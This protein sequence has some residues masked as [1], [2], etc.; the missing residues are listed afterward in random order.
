M[1]RRGLERCLL[2][3]FE[4]AGLDKMSFRS[5][6]E[7]VTTLNDQNEVAARLIEA[8]RGATTSTLSGC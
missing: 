7:C 1:E 5:G 4:H 6:H 8:V 3:D 2:D